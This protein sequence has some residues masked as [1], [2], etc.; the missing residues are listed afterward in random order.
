VRDGGDTKTRK[1]RRTL[2]LPVRC[3]EA[4]R[5]HR[6]QQGRDRERAG[7]KWNERG[8]VFSTGL[9]RALLAS[10]VSLLRDGG[11]SLEDIADLRGHAGTTV[12]GK[13]YRHQLRPVL[14][15]GAVAMDRISPSTSA[16][17]EA[18]SRS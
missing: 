13:V 14:L 18:S 9:G 11:V 8:L 10:S 16:K 2:A 3:V 17:P 5:L 7:R 6:D 4:L 12:T 15:G 1:S